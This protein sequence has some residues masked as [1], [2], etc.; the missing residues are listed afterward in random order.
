MLTMTM[1]ALLGQN[2]KKK[3]KPALQSNSGGLVDGILEVSI[4]PRDRKTS[5]LEG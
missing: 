4:L 3:I 5:N 1:D 2:S